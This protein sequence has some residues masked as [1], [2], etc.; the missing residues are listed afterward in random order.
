MDKSN[1]DL[2]VAMQHQRTSSPIDWT[3]KHVKAHRDE[4]PM[5]SLDWWASLNV[6]MDKWTKEYLRHAM[7][8]PRHYCIWKKVVAYISV[9][10]NNSIH[11]QENRSCWQSKANVSET[12]IDRADWYA[13]GAVMAK[14]HWYF[15]LSMCQA[16]LALLS[17]RSI[18]N[19]GTMTCVQDVGFQMMHLMCECVGV[20]IVQIGEEKHYRGLKGSSIAKRQFPP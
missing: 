13:I 3:F 17:F 5:Q 15:W 11:N 4:D 9:K 18:G 10:L 6:S 20:Q 7:R 16:W 8:T 12:S 1:Q 19:Y 2:I 14:W